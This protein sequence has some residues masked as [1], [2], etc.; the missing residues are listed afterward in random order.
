MLKE[1]Q[2]QP[3]ALR[4]LSGTIRK[5]R[6]PTAILISGEIGIGKRYAAINYAK[7][8]NCLEPIDN[9]SCD[10]C[11]S[12]KKIDSG[13]HPDVFIVEP[14]NDEI[15]IYDVRKL[16][17]SLCLKAFE[18]K[19][20]VAIIDG[21]EKMNESAANAFL[22][23]L[24][25]PPDNSIIILLSSNEDSLPETIKSRCVKVA[26]YPLPA[27]DCRRIISWHVSAD[28]LA[29]CT[30]LAMGRPGIMLRRNLP[31]EKAWFF[32]IYNDM[33]TDNSKDIWTNKEQMRIWLDMA[34]VFLRDIVVY[35]IT[36][37]ASDAL[38]GNAYKYSSIEK[39]LNVYETLLETSN[40]LGYNLNKSITWNYIAGEVKSLSEN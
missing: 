20:K 40:L 14:E 36:G 1:I 37:N 8:I 23:T 18:G 28:D 25:E 30:S 39:A 31:S 26:F 38:L 33:L 16:E 24:E 35:N 12:C 21:S 32:K 13:I 17:E 29:L 19:K 9:D 3:R 15:R 11:I 22:K 2:G 6:I 27:E 4:I 34:L 5:N 10:R 7:A